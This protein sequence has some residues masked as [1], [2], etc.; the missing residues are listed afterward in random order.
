V[1]NIEVK[2]EWSCVSVSQYAFI[3]SFALMLSHHTDCCAPAG[4]I[5][6]V[7]RRYHGAGLHRVHGEGQAGLDPAVYGPQVRAAEPRVP[8]RDVSCRLLVQALE[9]CGRPGELAGSCFSVTCDRLLCEMWRRV[10]A[11][12]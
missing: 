7:E 4:S 1:S 6:A 8:P 10:E 11:V 2:S 9:E 5:V 3:D 12:S